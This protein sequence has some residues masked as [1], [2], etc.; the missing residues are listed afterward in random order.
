MQGREDVE[1]SEKTQDEFF[2][3]NCCVPESPCQPGLVTHIL[4]GDV[5]GCG[6]APARRN[7]GCERLAQ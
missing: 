3:G 7:L 2:G 6:P 1:R 4:A 5:L